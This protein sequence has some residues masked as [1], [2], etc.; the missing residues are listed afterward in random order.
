MC[1]RVNTGDS[2]IF[3]FGNV[4]I[5]GGPLFNIPIIIKDI[6]EIQLCA[7]HSKGA[8]ITPQFSDGLAYTLRHRTSVMA[9]SEPILYGTGLQ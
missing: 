3:Y 5:C 8:F 9:Y 6:S 1:Q 4:Y 7:S 2:Y